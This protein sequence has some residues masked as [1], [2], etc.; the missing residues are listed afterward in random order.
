MVTPP[1]WLNGASREAELVPQEDEVLATHTPA[2]WA[3]IRPIL[4]QM[5]V[6]RIQTEAGCSLRE[7]RYLKPGEHHPRGD[8]DSRM[9]TSCAR[10]SGEMLERIH[11][12]FIPNEDVPATS[13]YAHMQIRG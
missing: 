7:T 3:A 6:G 5:P 9:N 8:R 1:H 4:D 12:L 11:A 2:A 10:Y 13:L